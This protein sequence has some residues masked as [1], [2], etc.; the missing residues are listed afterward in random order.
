MTSGK[1]QGMSNRTL[2]VTEKNVAFILPERELQ[3]GVDRGGISDVHHR[4]IGVPVVAQW[5]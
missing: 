5:K 3:E 4:R 2:K 1:L